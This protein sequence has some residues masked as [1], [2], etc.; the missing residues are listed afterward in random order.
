MSR[1]VR[2]ALVV[3]I[4]ALATEERVDAG[5]GRIELVMSRGGLVVGAIRWQDGRTGAGLDLHFYDPDRKDEES[6]NEITSTDI[7][8]RFR[9]R[10]PAG[11]YVVE[12][13]RRQKLV[14]TAQATASE[15]ERTVLEIE[16]SR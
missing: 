12:V 11:D 6:R 5:S 8:G 1:S 2:L 14:G 10:L 4:L 13:L 3:V 7:R 9:V 16:L 15:A